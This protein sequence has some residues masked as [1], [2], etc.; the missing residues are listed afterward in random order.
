MELF[1]EQSASK[2]Q[3]NTTWHQTEIHVKKQNEARPHLT[4]R[5]WLQSKQIQ[6]LHTERCKRRDVT[7]APESATASCATKYARGQQAWPSPA[8]LGPCIEISPGRLVRG[9]H[10][11]WPVGSRDRT[12]R[13]GGLTPPAIRPV[14]PTCSRRDTQAVAKWQ[15]ISCSAGA[16]ATT[17]SW[18]HFWICEHFPPHMYAQWSEYAPLFHYSLQLQ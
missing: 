7:T 10:G 8:V 13:S 1:L 16:Y 5:W 6:H 2:S 9:R 14:P 15:S 18:Q 3:L 17:V 11:A 4:T 12:D